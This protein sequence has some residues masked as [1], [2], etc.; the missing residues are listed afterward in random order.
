M[1]AVV[2]ADG[3]DLHDVRMGQLGRRLGL[4]LEALDELG[5][6]RKVLGDDLQR[7]DAAERF[8]VRFVDDRHSPLAELAKDPVAAQRASGKIGLCHRPIC[9]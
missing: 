7:D 3:V 2:L 1:H 8:L 9:S 6:V 4:A 5:V